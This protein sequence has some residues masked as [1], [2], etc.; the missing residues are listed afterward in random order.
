MANMLSH[1]GFMDLATRLATTARN[2]GQATCMEKLICQGIEEYFYAPEQHRRYTL[3]KRILTLK[4]DIYSLRQS[5]PDRHEMVVNVV[6]VK[7]NHGIAR[8]AIGISDNLIYDSNS[9]HAMELNG[10][11][12]DLVS[13]FHYHGIDHGKEFIIRTRMGKRR[14]NRSNRE[15]KK[16]KLSNV[17][18]SPCH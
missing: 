4:N 12:L 13:D 7:E 17:A 15:R 16:V 5:A 2:A 9:S 14:K 3:E 8:H 18:E 11:N 1:L 10:H 6:V